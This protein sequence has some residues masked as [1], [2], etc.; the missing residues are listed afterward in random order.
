MN[1]VSPPS[2]SALWVNAAAIIGGFA[3]FVLILVVAYLPQ[4]PEPLPEGMLTSAQRSERLTEM[5][6][7]E[8]AAATT[9]GWADQSNGV[10]RLPIERAMELTLNDLRAA[11]NH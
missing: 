11:R 8:H 7:K 4:K 6:A 1:N 5:R 2:T 10:V 3:I 9:Y